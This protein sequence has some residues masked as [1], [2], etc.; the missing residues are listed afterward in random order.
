MT[1]NPARYLP[2]MWDENGQHPRCV[3]CAKDLDEPVTDMDAALCD[4]HSDA[5]FDENDPEHCLP[6]W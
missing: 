1:I 6:I 2:S 4:D 5:E 3:V